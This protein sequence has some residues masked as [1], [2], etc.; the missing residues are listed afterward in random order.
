ML[1]GPKNY[2]YTSLFC[3]NPLISFF[4]LNTNPNSKNIAFDFYFNPKLL[5]FQ[6]KTKISILDEKQV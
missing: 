4:S 1:R 2:Q 6:K 3:K 5:F